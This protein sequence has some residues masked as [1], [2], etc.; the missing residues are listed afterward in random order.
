MTQHFSFVD[1]WFI[2]H[3]YRRIRI[4]NPS[5]R[6][7]V[8]PSVCPSL[9][10]QCE[11][12][13]PKKSWWSDRKELE[14]GRW[15]RPVRSGMG[16]IR[17]NSLWVCGKNTHSTMLTLTLGDVSNIY[18]DEYSQIAIYTRIYPPDRC[19]MSDQIAQKVCLTRIRIRIW[20]PFGHSW[21]RRTRATWPVA[22]STSPANRPY[23]LGVLVQ[24][25]LACKYEEK[26][27]PSEN[28]PTI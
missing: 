28:I 23:L 17:A 24:F 18:I 27:R 10:C 15:S 9:W 4:G 1:G 12:K 21:N 20:M 8:R 26:Q 25:E 22:E 11:V 6:P 13:V 19:V 7:S 3:I 14:S 5:V 16:Q 2:Q